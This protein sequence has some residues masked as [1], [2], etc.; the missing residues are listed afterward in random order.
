MSRVLESKKVSATMFVLFA[1]KVAAN[2]GMV[3]APVCRILEVSFLGTITSSGV[4]KYVVP[5]RTLSQFC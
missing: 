4:E 1:L 3:A 5:I 2:I